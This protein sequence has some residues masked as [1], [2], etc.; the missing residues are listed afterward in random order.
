[1]KKP[2]MVTFTISV[3]QMLP[4][5]PYIPYMDPMGNRLIGAKPI[6]PFSHG[7]PELLPG[8]APTPRA[9]APATR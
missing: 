2:Y 8:A 4:Y 9:A 6:V 5:I 3:P 1:M 7:P